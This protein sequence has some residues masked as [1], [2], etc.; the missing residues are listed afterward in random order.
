M[1]YFNIRINRISFFF[2]TILP[3][4]LTLSI[5]IFLIFVYIVPYFEEN[6]LNGK[7]E[8][9]REL[10]RST[11]SIASKYNEEVMAGRMDIKDAQE[12]AKKQIEFL[13]YGIDNKDYFWIT[14][15]YPN[16]IMHPYRSDLNGKDLSNFSDANGKK[17]FVE[18]VKIVQL[19]QEGYV[20]YMWQWMDDSN[21]I[22]PKISYVQE[23][24]PWG[25]IAGTGIYIEDVRRE[26]ANIEKNLVMVSLGISIIM[27]F[28]L[29][30]IVRQNLQTERKRSLAK[31]ELKISR[32]KYKALVEASADGAL[33]ILEDKCIYT[34]TK[35][36]KMLSYP[37][38]DP[39][40]NNLNNLIYK[41]RQEDIKNISDF[42]NSGT[43]SFLIETELISGNGSPVFVMLSIS[44]ITLSNKNGLIIVVKNLSSE[45]D[46]AQKNGDDYDEHFYML[47]D[48]L[49]IGAFR[50]VPGRKTKLLKSNNKISAIFDFTSKDDIHNA[51]I[52]DSIESSET[53][54]EFLDSLE[55]QE[56][57]QGF[58]LRIRTK[59]GTLKTLSV[60]ASNTKMNNTNPKF[61]E[62]I[63]IDITA[64]KKKEIIKDNLLQKLKMS[65]N[66]INQTVERITAKA[67][68]CAANTSI[69]AAAGLMTIHKK[70]AI[71]INST[72]EDCIG[73]VTDNDIRKRAVSTGISLDSPIHHIMSS[74]LVSIETSASISDALVLMNKL[75]LNH[76]VVKDADGDLKGIINNFMLGNYQIN[77]PD[78]L[79]AAIK[80]AETI[81][82]LKKIFTLI[83]YYI[84]MLVNSGTNIG[85]IMKSVTTAADLITARVAEIVISELGSPPSQFALLALGSEGRL[86]QSPSSDQDNAII[87]FD[88]P[89]NSNHIR[90]YFLKFGKRINLLLDEI[91]YILCKGDMMAGNPRWNQPGIT[92]KKYFAEWIM[93]PDPKNLLD[94]GAFFDLRSVYGD[95]Q[96]A[97]ELNDH[98]FQ[99]LKNNPAFFNYLARECVNYKIPLGIFGKIHAESSEA[100]ANSINIKNAIR[101][102]VNITRLYSIHAQIRETNTLSRLEILFE[103]NEI[104]HQNFNDLV[105]AFDYLSTLYFKYQSGQYI[106][107]KSMDSYIPISELSVTEINTLKTIFS[108]ISLIQSKIR[109]DFSIV[110]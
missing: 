73:I 108:Q 42:I 50:L 4:L 68:S 81:A 84:E 52:W 26:L 100:H 94:I 44:K 105:F 78:M 28:L 54:K 12:K 15:N 35:L 87:Y 63:I 80:K 60:Y 30:I 6:M 16:M 18:F 31:E 43:D 27:A 38:N 25:W 110:E 66:F 69:K 86:E 20:D 76:L 98:V 53:R 67:I 45:Y 7:K 93:T 89:D 40:F 24:K 33:M 62:G 36:I 83:P 107:N 109:H 55:E 79:Y 71:L 1:K 59:T 48:S 56:N 41:E 102:I 46:K 91:G 103:K 21:R 2:H 10:V 47:C 104:S 9:L 92:W 85:M 19:H 5:F 64:S 51:N 8:M 74:P 39:V 11:I 95:S 72:G 75:E 58:E 57:L 65:N 23:F 97:G 17:I 13:R 14:D 82:E 37:E 88:E 70:D 3:T 101:V 34:N 106:K 99:I 22:V 61:I 29:T 32:E 77:T 49:N 96:L 90:E